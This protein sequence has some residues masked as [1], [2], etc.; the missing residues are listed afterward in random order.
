MIG[1]EPRRESSVVPWDRGIPS[2]STSRN[3]ITKWRKFGAFG[4]L[5]CTPNRPLI[6]SVGVMG[7]SSVTWWMLKRLV[8]EG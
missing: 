1:V 7:L 2:A 5:A 8:I 3:D 4:K 6:S